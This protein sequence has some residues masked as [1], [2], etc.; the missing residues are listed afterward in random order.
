MR[1]IGI[2]SGQSLDGALQHFVPVPRVRLGRDLCSRHGMLD[3]TCGV[4]VGGSQVW[5][6]WCH[7]LN[8]TD[9]G[10]FGEERREQY[11]L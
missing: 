7:L 10:L 6:R 2:R 11:D 9:P 8:D 3:F 1:R 5:D 4:P